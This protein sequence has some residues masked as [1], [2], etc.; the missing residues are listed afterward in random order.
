MKT[1]KEILIKHYNDQRSLEGF[2]QTTLYRNVLSAM[3]EIAELAFDAG[4]EYKTYLT[5]DEMEEVTH[6]H[7][8]PNKETFIKQNF[9]NVV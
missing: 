8:F 7:L 3:K 9:S 5:S 1:A 6:K 2:K 4:F